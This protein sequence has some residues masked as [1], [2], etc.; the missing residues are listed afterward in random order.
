MRELD[1]IRPSGGCPTGSAVITGAGN[2][3]AKFV[4]H[5]VGPIWRGGKAKES[6]LLASAYQK[7]LELAAGKSAQSI[8][9]PSISTGVYGYPVGQAA[10]L[11]LETVVHFLQSPQSIRTVLF[12]LFDT[13]TFAVYARSLR[14]LTKSL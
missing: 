7:S 3:P 5:A 13:N 12:V 8:S 1:R 14:E 2:L 6:K 4:V 10:P 11:A 9:F